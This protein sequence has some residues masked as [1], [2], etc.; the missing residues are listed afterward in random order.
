[1]FDEG[2][3]IDRAQ[4]AEAKLGGLQENLDRVK[5]KFRDMMTTL[6]ARELSNGTVEFNFEVLAEN[7]SIE[8]ALKLRAAIDKQHRISGGAGE[9]PRVRVA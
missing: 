9:K 5:Q 4:S 2:S 6:G 1:M 3:A 8:S 7:L